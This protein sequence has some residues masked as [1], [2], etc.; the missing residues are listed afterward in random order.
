MDYSVDLKKSIKKEWTEAIKKS[1]IL[2]KCITANTSI[3]WQHAAHTTDQLSSPN[4]QT[5]AT[6]KSL[7]LNKKYWRIFWKKFRRKDQQAEN[8]KTER[9]KGLGRRTR[10]N[11]AKWNQMTALRF[12]TGRETSDIPGLPSRAN[13]NS[14]FLS[15]VTSKNWRWLLLTQM[16]W[17]NFKR[18]NMFL[19]FYKGKVRM[20]SSRNTLENWGRGCSQ[21]TMGL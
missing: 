6:Q 1:K 8:G 7:S 5:G 4:R 9:L 21:I 3:I 10:E 20:F 19:T 13:V 12:Q 14:R 11:I 18:G 16:V 2:Y 17:G 15:W